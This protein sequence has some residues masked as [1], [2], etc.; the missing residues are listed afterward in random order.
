[1]T[2]GLRSDAH[3][4]SQLTKRAKNPLESGC[5]YTSNS[6]CI[7]TSALFF[8]QAR[9][10]GIRSRKLCSF[11]KQI[12]ASSGPDLPSKVERKSAQKQS[13]SRYLFCFRWATPSFH[14]HGVV[15][16]G[17]QVRKTPE[18]WQVQGNK[19]IFSTFLQATHDWGKSI[20]LAEFQFL[21]PYAQV[22][23]RWSLVSACQSFC[24]EFCSDT[25]LALLSF[26][27]PPITLSC[28]SFS[29]FQALR[30]SLY[31]PGWGGQNSITS[32]FIVWSALV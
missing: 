26:P 3:N 16:G 32:A 31:P 8:V 29:A 11:D 9:S 27:A 7:S 28:K 14:H 18:Q 24:E 25:Y 5:L 15:C 2:L 4:F 13:A 20:S 17:D 19:P 30:D 22:S 10:A 23:S 21:V 6:S 1:M 12:D